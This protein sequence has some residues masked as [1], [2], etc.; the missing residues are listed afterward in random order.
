MPAPWHAALR[1][2]RSELPLREDEDPDIRR[3]RVSQLAEDVRRV[4]S[5]WEDAKESQGGHGRPAVEEAVAKLEREMMALL[6]EEELVINRQFDKAAA[7]RRRCQRVVSRNRDVIR[8]ALAHVRSHGGRPRVARTV[9]RSGTRVSAAFGLA[10]KRRAGA[11]PQRFAAP[12]PRASHT[13]AR[14]VGGSRSGTSPPECDESDCSEPGSPG[15]WITFETFRRLTP[16]CS[17]PERLARFHKLPPEIQERT[18]LALAR[19]CSANA[20]G[21]A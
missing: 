9:V 21:S 1:A 3:T 17:G 2:I 18:W 10:E 14:R 19:K 12:R 8:R 20:E 5:A 7:G 6:L 13:S 15:S 4:R 16:D 11:V